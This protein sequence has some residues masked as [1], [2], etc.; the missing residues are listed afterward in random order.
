MPM[1]KKDYEKFAQIFLDTK[2][3][4]PPHAPDFGRYTVWF[5]VLIRMTDVFKDDNPR[6]D[7]NR[8][9]EACGL[10]EED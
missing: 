2:P 4:R 5:S 10:N 7:R 3:P 6:F 1:S 8:F 9:L